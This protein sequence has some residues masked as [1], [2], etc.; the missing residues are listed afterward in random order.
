[1][2]ED[3]ENV[4][5]GS[6]YV[7]RTPRPSWLKQKFIFSTSIQGYSPFIEKVQPIQFLVKVHFL[8][9]RWLPS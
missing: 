4:L 8:D 2:L 7:T 3:E 1:M 6:E 9:Y 5:V